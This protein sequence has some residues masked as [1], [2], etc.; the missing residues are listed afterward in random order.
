MY[1]NKKNRDRYFSFSIKRKLM[2]CII[3]YYIS[4]SHTLI[5]L[6]L[7][8]L[9]FLVSLNWYLFNLQ[10]LSSL[11]SYFPIVMTLIDFLINDILTYMSGFSIKW[12]FRCFISSLV[13]ID[14]NDEKVI[15]FLQ[16]CSRKKKN[17]F[18]KF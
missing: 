11:L 5:H 8:P 7:T 15:G 1:L 13:T 10:L 9:C 6:S 2:F 16:I 18:G 14:N 17:L 3:H 12:Q 4:P